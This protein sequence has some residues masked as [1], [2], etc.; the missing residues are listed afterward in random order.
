MDPLAGTAT[1]AFAVF[2][3]SEALARAVPLRGAA[4][5]DYIKRR[6]VR[7]L[8]RMGFVLVAIVLVTGLFHAPAAAATAGAL[9][10]WLAAAAREA[11]AEHRAFRC[12]GADRTARSMP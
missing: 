7:F 1:A 5:G 11:Y 3:G 10:G 8:G 2:G 9:A 12:A 4:F 6:A